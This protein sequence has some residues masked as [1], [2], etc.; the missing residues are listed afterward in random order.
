MWFYLSLLSAFLNALSNVAR[1]THGSLADPVELSWWCLLFGLPLGVGLVMVSNTPLWTSTA[2]I[3]PATI[4]SVLNAVASILIFRAYKLGDASVV[5]PIAN[6]LP[7]FLIFTSLIMLRQVPSPAGLIGILLIVGGVY[8]SSVNGRHHVLQPLKEILRNRGSRAMLL[9]ALILAVSTVFM[10]I[11]LQSAS[12]SYLL[13]YQ[14]IIGLCC[15][16]VYLLMRPIRKRVRHGEKVLQRWG[17]HMAA[18]SLFSTTAIFFQYQA[19]AVADPNYV[20]AVKRL[21][22]VMTVL[23]AGLFLKEKH[24]LRRFKGSAIALIGVIIIYFVG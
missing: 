13:M 19:M 6:F 5:A 3:L 8:Y 20:L 23:L 10:K 18:I 15:M 1:R 12:S 17:W 24:I 4:A 11:A 14:T 22:V 9:W 21:D 7:V 16:S 2:Y